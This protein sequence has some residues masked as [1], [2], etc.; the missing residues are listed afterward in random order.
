MIYL[1]C[2][3]DHTLYTCNTI[4]D[5]LA[6]VRRG[7]LERADDA[8]EHGPGVVHVA[9]EEAEAPQRHLNHIYIY[10]IV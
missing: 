1:K 5:L 10:I 2:I 9:V 4:S 7:R 8:D 6:V 3:L